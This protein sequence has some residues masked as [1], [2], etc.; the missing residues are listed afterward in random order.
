[1]LYPLLATD[2]YSNSSIN[3]KQ[4]TIFFSQDLKSS[5]GLYDEMRKIAEANADFVISFE[6]NRAATKS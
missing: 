1:M 2:F 3:V 5:K 6:Q 4:F